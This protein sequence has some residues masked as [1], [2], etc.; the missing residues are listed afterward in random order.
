MSDTAVAADLIRKVSGK[1][2]YGDKVKVLQERAFVALSS[3]NPNDWTRRRVRTL[4]E[5][6]A[7]RVELREAIE[8][9]EAIAERKR[10]EDA[11]SDHR[12]FVRKTAW[13]EALL[14]VTDPDFHGDQIEALRVATGRMD[15]PG[16]QGNLTPQ[17]LAEE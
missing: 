6:K 1:P 16:N 17:T 14:T 15:R 9:A 8:M 4:W 2:G 10:L 13:L 3:I 5:G 11:Q 7:A 12:E